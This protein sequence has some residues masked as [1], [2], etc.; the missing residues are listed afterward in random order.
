MQGWAD[1]RNPLEWA[2]ESGATN[3][4]AYLKWVAQQWH[5]D[6]YDCFGRTQWTKPFYDCLYNLRT[7][8]PQSN[9]GSD[10]FRL[11]FM[12]TDGA[13]WRDAYPD[14]NNYDNFKKAQLMVKTGGL[15]TVGVYLQTA[16][17]ATTARKNSYYTYCISSC[18]DKTDYGKSL[19]NKAGAL[20]K[21]TGAGKNTFLKQNELVV[22][23]F[24]GRLCGVVTLW[25]CYFVAL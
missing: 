12:V 10:A 19:G 7:E 24:C 11:C 20:D 13:P 5:D 18:F 6:W 21:T 14:G 1:T 2:K 9:Q 4:V 22:V 8:N 3:Q 25:R 15:E 16:S 23:D 17:S